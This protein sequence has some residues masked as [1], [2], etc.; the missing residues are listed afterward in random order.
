[1]SDTKTV[2]EELRASAKFAATKSEEASFTRGAD[3]LA[4]SQARV[5]AL[6]GIKAEAERIRNE[7]HYRGDIYGY[8]LMQTILAAGE[9]KHE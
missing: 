9:V 2:L 6:E 4:A 7:A 3:A 8:D 1:M 5:E